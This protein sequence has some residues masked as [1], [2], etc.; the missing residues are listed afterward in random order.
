MK[1]SK[2]LITIVIAIA[3]LALVAVAN[4]ISFNN[5][6]VAFDNTITAQV[7]DMTANYNKY[8]NQVKESAQ[9]PTQQIAKLKEIYELIIS[10]RKSGNEM[11]KLIVEANLPIEQSTF[12]ELQRIIVSGRNEIYMIQKI[13]ID[14][15]REYNTY[16]SIFPNNII[17]KTFM[18]KTKKTPT[19]PIISEVQEVFDSGKDKTVGVF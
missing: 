4:I 7:S 13:H 11:A 15:V 6:V 12:I 14:T 18:H 17:N 9:V 2:I 3:M 19:T 10:G 16:I 8:F 5:A 1:A